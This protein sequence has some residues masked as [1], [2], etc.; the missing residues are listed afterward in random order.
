MLRIFTICIIFISLLYSEEKGNPD[1]SS[2]DLSPY[3]EEKQKEIAKVKQ[4]QKELL[5]ENAR[6]KALSK[7]KEEQ[8][9]YLQAEQRSLLFQNFHLLKKHYHLHTWPFEQQQSFRKAEQ[10]FKPLQ[11]KP[12]NKTFQKKAHEALKHL[13]FIRRYIKAP[14]QNLLL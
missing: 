2:L 5:K 8:I 14:T 10:I 7:T 9:E 1:L 6:L 11:D 4:K 12:F 3:F 13:E